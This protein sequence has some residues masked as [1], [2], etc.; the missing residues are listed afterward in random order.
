MPP[1]IAIS[2]CLDDRGRWRPGRRYQY[3]DLDY[4]R[5]L[6]DAGGVPFF[7]PLQG[8]AEQA[9]AAADGLLLPG[10]DDL[11]P[12]QPYPAGVAFDPVP[13]EQLHFDRAL[14]A[15]ATG[16]GLPVLGICYGMQ[17]LALEHGGTLHYD[18]ETDLPKAG[19]H[20]LGDPEARH[21][22]AIEAG[23]RLAELAGGREALVNSTHHQAVAAPGEGLRVSARAADGVVEAL[24]ADSEPFRVGVQWHPEKGTGALDRALFRA[25]V[26]AC[27]DARPS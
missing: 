5:A 2:L 17:L 25:F 6:D 15:A 20:R 23:T 18:I 26:A 9:L 4:A 13:D 14:L 27:G 1:R 22:I 11:L 16:R 3:A 8:S 10:G 12:Q 7:V 21:A 19:P 24:E